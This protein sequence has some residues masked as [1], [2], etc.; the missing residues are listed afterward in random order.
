MLT[1]HAGMDPMATFPLSGFVPC[2][3][4]SRKACGT[5]NKQEFVSDQQDLI[6]SQVLRLKYQ[7]GMK[8]IHI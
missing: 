8:P 6:F 5:Y 7:K 4:S 2:T 3:G 1:W